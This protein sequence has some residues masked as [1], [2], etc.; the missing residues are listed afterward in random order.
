M[1]AAI[2]QAA[3]NTGPS[4]NSIASFSPWIFTVGAAAHDRVYSNSVVLGNITISGDLHLEPLK[5]LCICWFLLPM[6]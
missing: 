2:D 6:L 5:V 4:P 1:V 3:G